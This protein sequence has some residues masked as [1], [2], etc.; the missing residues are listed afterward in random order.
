MC[1]WV[2][3]ECESHE[4]MMMMMMM[5]YGVYEVFR[6]PETMVFFIIMLSTVIREFNGGHG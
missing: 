1:V 5:C 4:L 2:V 6:L 3:S